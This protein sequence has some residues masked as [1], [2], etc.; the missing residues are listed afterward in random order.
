MPLTDLPIPDP[1]TA[2]PE[3]IATFIKEADARADRFVESRLD[4]PVAGFVPSDFA[5]AYRALRMVRENHLATGNAVCEWGSG[6]GAVTILAAMLGFDACGIE[7]NSELVDESRRLAT[8]F[9]S[10]AQFVCGSFLPPGAE[11]FADRANDG[12]SWLLTDG[13]DGHEE[14]GLDPEDFDVIFAYP[15]PGEE[16]VIQAIF[17]RYGAAGAMLITYNGVEGMRMHRKM[18]ARRGR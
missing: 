8:D 10:R 5:A 4:S 2:L 13:N 16:N 14:L 12:L 11:H 1:R 6:I 15:W 7:I 18:S 17:E 3:N 9:G